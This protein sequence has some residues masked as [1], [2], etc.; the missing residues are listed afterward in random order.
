MHDYT[1]RQQILQGGKCKDLSRLIQYCMALLAMV[2]LSSHG[3]SV[4]VHEPKACTASLHHTNAGLFHS[5]R[6]SLH[7]IHCWRHVVRTGED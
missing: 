1:L 6:L 5:S 2:Q 4:Y 3:G 7:A